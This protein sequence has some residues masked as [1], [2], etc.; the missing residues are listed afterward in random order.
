MMNL[1]KVENSAARVKTMAFSSTSQKFVTLKIWDAEGSVLVDLKNVQTS[2]RAE[3]GKLI[4]KGSTNEE[5]GAFV[6]SISAIQK[7]VDDSNVIYLDGRYAPE[8]IPAKG[9]GT[10]AKDA[11]SDF[12]K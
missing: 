1:S 4:P 5:I 12:L 6:A 9:K 10:A 8:G 7:H 11:F 2:P 3:L